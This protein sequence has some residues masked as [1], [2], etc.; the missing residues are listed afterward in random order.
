MWQEEQREEIRDWVLTMSMD[1]RLEQVLP[2][3]ER[4]SYE[5]SLVAVSTGVHSLP[6]LITG[7]E[8]AERLGAEAALRVT[9]QKAVLERHLSALDSLADVSFLMFQPKPY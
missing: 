5:A 1:Q 9:E 8:M 2:R 7:E 6:C 4:D 3:D